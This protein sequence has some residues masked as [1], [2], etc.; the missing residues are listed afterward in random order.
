MKTI[1]HVLSIV[2]LA[3][4]CYG[5]EQKAHDRAWPLSE[6]PKRFQEV[7]ESLNKLFEEGGDI[8]LPQPFCSSNS[9]Y[10]PVINEKINRSN[11]T[12]LHI[13]SMFGTTEAVKILIDRGANLEVC[14]RIG[15]T[16]LHRSVQK[17]FADTSKLLIASG[18]DV[19]AKDQS[20]S[21]PLFYAIPSRERSWSI[22]NVIEICN[23]LIEAGADVNAKNDIFY[24]PLHSAVTSSHPEIVECLLEKGAQVN[25]RTDQG[26]TPLHTA[27][28]GGE[29]ET[30]QLLLAYGAD[31]NAKNH[32]G[33]TPLSEAKSFINNER[34]TEE[35]QK[36]II[37]FLKANGAKE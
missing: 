18:A 31:I 4:L 20:Q 17:G 24:T 7:T 16:P 23:S 9:K 26:N 10:G 35:R 27:T 34:T 37:R 12:P 6:E 28:L 25:A 15:A 11:Y 19:N 32:Y 22:H 14:D 36:E 21:T 33:K 3:I 13:A 29:I 1:F 8:N 5:C 30:F 2:L